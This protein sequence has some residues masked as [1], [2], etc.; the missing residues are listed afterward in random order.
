M[1]I[2]HLSN[3]VGSSDHYVDMSDNHVDSSDIIL[4]SIWQFGAVTRYKKQD[5]SYLM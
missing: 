5:V 2:R 1:K 4:T 3:Y